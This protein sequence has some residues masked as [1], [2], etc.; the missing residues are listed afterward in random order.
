M[1]PK[2]NSFSDFFS[3][4][5][6][7]R[8]KIGRALCTAIGPQLMHDQLFI[9]SFDVLR[10]YAESLDQHMKMMDMGKSCTLCSTE[11]NS[12]GC[13]SL[14]MAGET[15]AIQ[16]LMNMLNGVAVHL[17]RDD[18]KECSFL[19]E[20]GCI[21][22]FKPIFCLNYNCNKIKTS[23]CSEDLKKLER[24]T[25]KLLVKQYE[26]ETMLLARI[27][28]MTSGHQNGDGESRSAVQ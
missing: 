3:G 6:E 15:D 28:S 16:F 4:T 13:C 14:T 11:N 22:T 17:V 20:R 27:G 18:G 21:F 10:D 23:A 25:G 19:G 8:L 26:I 2:Q 7:S 1:S 24:L 5:V 9:Q 12:G